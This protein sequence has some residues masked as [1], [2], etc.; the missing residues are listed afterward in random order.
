MS[1][2]PGDPYLPPGC[3]E[4]DIDIASG[5]CVRCDSCRSYFYPD[6]DE[7][8]CKRCSLDPDLAREDKLESE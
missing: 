3:S 6:D 4:R 8:T 7:R 1:D 5:S 2:L